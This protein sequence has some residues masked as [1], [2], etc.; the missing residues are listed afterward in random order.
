MA[1]LQKSIVLS[2][3]KKNTDKIVFDIATVYLIN[4]LEK[5]LVD[6]IK[7]ADRISDLNKRKSITLA[8][9]VLAIEQVEQ[10]RG[11]I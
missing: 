7:T 3:I 10:R 4:Y 9:I 1:R 11:K 5:N 2:M 8:D 6:I